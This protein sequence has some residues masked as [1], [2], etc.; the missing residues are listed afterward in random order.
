MTG[1]RQVGREI[2]ADHDP[3]GRCLGLVE[4]AQFLDQGIEIG[5]REFQLLHAGE[6]EE[7]LEDV[8]EPLNLLLE[9]TD[10]LLDATVPRGFG[11]LKIL[12]Q[13]VEIQR[14]GG[15]RVADL[16]GQAAGELRDLGILGAEPPGDVVLGGIW[17]RNVS[18]IGVRSGLPSHC[19]RYCACGLR[20]RVSGR[21]RGRRPCGSL[22]GTVG[23]STGDGIGHGNGSR[24]T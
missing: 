22:E 5:R 4:I 10:A 24:V 12:L 14:Q 23:N 8:V 13:E 7:V 6:P 20:P 2:G 1:S 18:C 21:G 17:I 9:P 3:Q 15:Q 11:S 16:V 19:L